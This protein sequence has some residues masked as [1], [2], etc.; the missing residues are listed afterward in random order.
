[1]PRRPAFDTLRDLR[2]GTVIDELDDKL[3]ALVQS[4][5]RTEKPG[6]LVLTVHVG[7][8]KGSSEA[9]VV[10][11]D[12]VAKEPT[13]TDNGTIMFPTPEGNLTR[14]NHKQREL[15]GIVLADSGARNG[16]ED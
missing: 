6:K 11:A 4:V 8:A 9:L 15:P 7:P 10:R 13:L 12:I 3:Q 5:Q 16:T 14:S 1:M 2:G